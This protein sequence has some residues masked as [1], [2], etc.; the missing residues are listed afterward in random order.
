MCHAIN[1]SAKRAAQLVL[2]M[3]SFSRKSDA[4]F[5]SQEIGRLMDAALELAMNDYD[6][7]KRYDFRRIEIVRH[8]DGEIPLVPCEATNIQQVFLNIVKNAAYALADKQFV[9]DAPRLMI[10]IR[11]DEQVMTV[12]IADNGPG[13]DE[14]TRKR[15]F[16]PFFTTKPVGLGTGLGMSIAYFIIHDQH[17]GTI[18]VQSE[19]GKGTAF[20]VRLPYFRV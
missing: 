8:Y 11:A 19:P 16:E 12:E 9:D 5:S 15:I 6:L 4:S 1:D 10:A 13:M 7:K 2:N 14:K 20:T 18:Q 17:K 3:L